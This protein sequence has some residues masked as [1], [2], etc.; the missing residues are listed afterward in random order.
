MAVEIKT[1][2]PEIVFKKGLAQASISLIRRNREHY[3]TSADKSL[4]RVLDGN[5]FQEVLDWAYYVQGEDYEDAVAGVGSALDEDIMAVAKIDTDP[6]AI[7]H[8]VD[9]YGKYAGKVIGELNKEKPNDALSGNCV[10]TGA[11]FLEFLTTDKEDWVRT[12]RM[13]YVRT[14]GNVQDVYASKNCKRNEAIDQQVSDALTHASDSHLKHG[15]S[16]IS[17]RVLGHMAD[18]IKRDFDSY[19]GWSGREQEEAVNRLTGIFIPAFARAYQWSE[20]SGEATEQEKRQVSGIMDRV[21]GVITDPPIVASIVAELKEL[22]NLHTARIKDLT[23]GVIEKLSGPVDEQSLKDAVDALRQLQA[24]HDIELT[25]RFNLDTMPSQMNGRLVECATD[26][27][28]SIIQRADGS[29]IATEEDIVRHSQLLK[30]AEASNAALHAVVSSNNSSDERLQ[31]VLDH[32]I[33]VKIREVS[34]EE[35]GR[36]IARKNR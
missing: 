27:Y 9:L 32:G 26:E 20:T 5:F 7:D 10:Q 18:G 24:L 25:D 19:D 14:A 22:P 6:L 15:K 31:R 36:K 35:K 30:M 1:H 23:A 21:K 11:K 16:D 8:A 17:R 12:H 34:T 3:A 29:E 4:P 13:Q 33:E 28:D 2:N